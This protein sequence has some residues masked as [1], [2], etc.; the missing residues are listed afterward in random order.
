MRSNVQHN[1]DKSKFGECYKITCA[2]DK[3]SYTVHTFKNSTEKIDIE[4]KTKGQKSDGLQW[5]FNFYC[6]DPALVCNNLTSCPD[7]CNYR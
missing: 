4:C 3:K 6:E 7:D 1:S 5:S 2:S